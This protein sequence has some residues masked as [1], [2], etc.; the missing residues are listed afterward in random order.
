V[1]T[2]IDKDKHQALATL[3]NG[4][5][6]GCA[7]DLTEVLINLEDNTC[8]YVELIPVLEDIVA[9]DSFYYFD[10][11]GAGGQPRA[12]SRSKTSF[13]SWAQQAI[14][15]IKENATFESS[16]KIHEA[17]TS[18]NTVLSNPHWSNSDP[19]AG[20]VINH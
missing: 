11:N 9:V 12:D 5:V 13:K 16:S 6:N 19:K 4:L 2:E 7:D 18:N 1:E 15:S 8:N 14:E 10:D 20:L 3:R 17:L